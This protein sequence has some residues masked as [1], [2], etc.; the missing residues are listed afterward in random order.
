MENSPRD[1][2][3]N[4]DDSNGESATKKSKKP[5]HLGVMA[6]G[7]GK[8]AKSG[9]D[10]SPWFS[11]RRESKD[12][13]AKTPEP[14]VAETLPSEPEI[15]DHDNLPLEKP[16]SD[17]IREVV[18]PNLVEM[19]EEIEAGREADPETDAPVEKFRELVKDGEAPTEAMHEV[20][21]DLGLEDDEIASLDTETV[22]PEAGEV[23]PAEIEPEYHE[24]P[25]EVEPEVDE[26]A[27][28]PAAGGSG[29]GANQ[30]GGSG[31]GTGAAGGGPAGPGGGVPGGPGG[32]GPP[33]PGFGAP[34]FGPPFGPGWRPN[35]APTP[36]TPNTQ[37]R[38]PEYAYASPAAMALFGGIIGYLVGRRRGRIKTEKRLIPVQKK[39]EKEVKNLQFEIQQKEKTIRQAAREKV[40]KD[41]IKVVEAY[42]AKTTKPEN[43]EPERR[44]A[45]EARALHV[46]EHKPEKIGHV[47]VASEAKSAEKAPE[48]RPAQPEKTAAEHK[49]DHITQRQVETLN[50]EE[51]LTMSEKIMVNGSTLRQIYE[52]HLIGERGL[53]RLVG[54]HLRGGDLKKA[55]QQEILERE[56]DFERD[57]GLRDL[58]P[59]YGPSSPSGGSGSQTALKQMV[60]KAT[61][62]IGQSSEEVAYYRARAAYDTEQQQVEDHQRRALDL[63]LISV[64]LILL[65][66]V[67]YLVISGRGS[68]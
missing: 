41:G 8:E 1:T 2:I 17:E 18:Q 6:I 14:E 65:F 24:I 64:I 56:L 9:K 12:E 52:T 37:A 49:F 66:L 50:R 57:P 4:D 55:L 10:E 45:P 19:I 53:R 32:F 34:R 59:T 22:V 36:I 21:S 15:F 40:Q 29:A 23:E 11:L 38:Q 39:L 7:K 46:T 44:R 26:D 63:A 13:T 27:S 42:K 16:S 31:G 54:E 20:L 47:I 28:Q 5:A 61:V 67:V 43:I 25:L 60:E 48:M 58:S 33:G 3:E 62:N 68:L 35:V 51:L 30:T